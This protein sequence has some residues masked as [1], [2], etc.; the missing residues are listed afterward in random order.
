MRCLSARSRSWRRSCSWSWL[1]SL[2]RESSHKRTFEIL[3]FLSGSREDDPKQRA[4]ALVALELDP[5]SI[6]FNCP[7]CDGQAQ[8]DAT[9]IARPRVVHAIETLEYPLAVRRGNAR[10]RVLHL[11]HRLARRCL[12]RDRKSTRLNSS[13]LG[14]SYAVFCLKK[15][16]KRHMVRKDVV[17]SKST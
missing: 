13:H 15:K 12:R 9:G 17:G 11:D 4:S 5:P 14:I 3:T 1:G 10:P 7:P 16:I 2:A 6:G 8:S